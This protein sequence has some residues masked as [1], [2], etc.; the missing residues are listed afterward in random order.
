MSDTKESNRGTGWETPWV[1]I[2]LCLMLALA[3][4]AGYFAVAYHFERQQLETHAAIGTRVLANLAAEAPQDWLS[5]QRQMTN[6]L[7]PNSDSQLIISDGGAETVRIG[8]QPPGPN[9]VHN[10]VIQRDGRVIGTLQVVHSLRGTVWRTVAFALL[11]LVLAGAFYVLYRILPQRTVQGL[12]Q[13]LS[14]SHKALEEE[15][16]AKERALKKAEH[17]GQAIKHLA[18][19]DLLTDLPNRSMLHDHLQDAI[20]EMESRGQH[21]ALLIMD[22]D[23]FKEINDTL[24]HNKGDLVLREVGLRLRNSIK[25]TDLIARLGG[26]EFAVMLT[27]LQKLEV[28]VDVANRIMEVLDEPFAIDGYNFDVSASLGIVLFPDHGNDAKSLM[29]RADVAMY[30]AKDSNRDFVIYSP[31]IDPNSL[32]HLTLK[33]ELRTAI[34]KGDLLVYFQPKIDLASGQIRAVE[35][36]VRWVH[37]ERGFVGPDQFIPVAEHTGLIH[38]LTGLVFNVSLSQASIW[39]QA[40]LNIGV[41]I[42]ISVHSLHDSFLPQRVGEMLETWSVP[43]ELLTLEVTESAIMAEP[44]RALEVLTELSEMGVHIS[45]DDYGTGYSSLSYLKKLPVKEI[46]I[47]RSFVSDMLNNEND[48]VIVRATIDMAHDLGLQV[49]AEGIEDQA[50]WD[51]LLHLGCDQA[52]GFYMS[53]PLPAR[54]LSQWLAESPWG[55]SNERKILAR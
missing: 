9:L 28:V 55:I 35:S 52:Q 31:E 43:P 15:V 5:S 13:Q 39:R 22:L 45:V 41:A 46:K 27:H 17:T 54:D 29:Q 38:P 3:L 51:A 20:H 10:R 21:L 24:G 50:T 6:Q 1:I 2:G 12:R 47:D 4:P 33:G 16:R 7:L 42:N 8:V 37:P 14:A 48:A 25:D 11:G 53:K 18:Y 44:Q 26:D 40:G 36:L 32:S 49:T 30:L 23:N 19:H 34:E